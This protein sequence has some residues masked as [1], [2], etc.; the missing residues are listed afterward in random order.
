[1]THAISPSLSPLHSH[2]RPHP[3][4]HPCTQRRAWSAALAGAIVAA[5]GPTPGPGPIPPPGRV[6]DH[7]GIARCYVTDRGTPGLFTLAP[8]GPGKPVPRFSVVAGTRDH[9]VY[10]A[11]SPGEPLEVPLDKLTAGGRR[12]DV[13]V[14]LG[15]ASVRD[16]FEAKDDGSLNRQIA[17]QQA[18]APAVEVTG[19]WTTSASRS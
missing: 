12:L 18:T 8:P 7:G 14:V 16:R 6:L 15:E 2:P 10:A 4:P 1:M 17:N 3:C 5:C 19:G 13:F 9:L 11:T